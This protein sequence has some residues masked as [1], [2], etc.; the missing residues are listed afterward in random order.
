[1]VA[2]VDTLDEAGL[3]KRA[4]AIA[5]EYEGQVSAFAPV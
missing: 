5:V 3:L 4:A 2:K 1:M